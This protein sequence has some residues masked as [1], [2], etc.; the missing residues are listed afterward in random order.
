CRLPGH[1]RSVKLHSRRVI[2]MAEAT[3]TELLGFDF[4]ELNQLAQS[5]SQ[6]EYRARQLFHAIYAERLQSLDS[7]STLPKEFRSALQS[8]GLAIGQPRKDRSFASNDGTI[9][10]LIAMA[11]GETVETVWM[12][13]AMAARLETAAKLATL[14]GGAPRYA[15]PA[16]W[17]AP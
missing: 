3:K 15:F 8:E 5:Y 2:S 1:C 11:D 12:P 7:I 6:P 4:Q 10:Y 17:A 9:R 14:N 16:R 13:R